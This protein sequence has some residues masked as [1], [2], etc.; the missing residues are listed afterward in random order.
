MCAA[1]ARP[2]RGSPLER[3]VLGGER[4]TA[5]A[6][7]ANGEMFA[8]SGQRIAL[9]KPTSTASRSPSFQRKEVILKKA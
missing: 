7:H 8:A 2:A 6:P 4:E 3:Y 5:S 9:P 1:G